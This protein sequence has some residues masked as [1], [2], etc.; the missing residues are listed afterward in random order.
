MNSIEQRGNNY[1]KGIMNCSKD[2][3]WK[4]WPIISE[5][6]S[7]YLTCAAGFHQ[8][9][10]YQFKE[11]VWVMAQLEDRHARS[12]LNSRC[13][14]QIL[15]DSTNSSFYTWISQVITSCFFLANHKLWFLHWLPVSTNHSVLGLWKRIPHLYHRYSN[16]RLCFL[17]LLHPRVNMVFVYTDT[18]L[19]VIHY[20]RA[21]LKCS[22]GLK[23][24]KPAQAPEDSQ[25][26][27]K[28]NPAKLPRC[29]FTGR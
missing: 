21:S 28:S 15:V 14:E 8:N 27:S 4:V 9:S 11:K 10:Y 1:R 29:V 17:S 7:H 2:F 16:G 25:Y 18:Q 5:F 20:V 12:R 19:S 13:I 6:F 23:I 22:R 24:V 26:G 3:R